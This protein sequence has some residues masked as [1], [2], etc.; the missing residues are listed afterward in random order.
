[1]RYFLI[2]ALLGSLLLGTGAPARPK[3]SRIPKPL[4]PT[5]AL[6]VGKIITCAGD[7]IVN[8]T[9]LISKGKI[10]AIGPRDKIKVPAGYTEIDLG[11]KF[12]MPGLVD[13]HSHIGGSGDINEMVYSTNPELRVFDVIKPNN[14]QLKVA[15]AGGVTTVCFI[16]GSGTNMGGWGTLM[17]TGPGIARRSGPAAAR[18]A[19]NRTS[20]GNP[21]RQ[22]RQKSAPVV[23][24]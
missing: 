22:N 5:L 4:K 12:A 11:D 19:Q 18:R 13:V 7:P 1:M 14:D 8:G 20:G 9:I 24:A 23:W 2:P 17:K 10:E 3:I 15:V 21:E 16:P 6:H